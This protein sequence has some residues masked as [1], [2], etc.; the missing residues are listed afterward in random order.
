[1]FVPAFT[2]F[3]VYQML[4]MTVKHVGTDMRLHDIALGV[5]LF[6]MSLLLAPCCYNTA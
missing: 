6:M 3:E 1:M 5:A 2:A 4:C